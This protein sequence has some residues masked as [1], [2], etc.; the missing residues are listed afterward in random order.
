MKLYLIKGLLLCS[1]MAQAQ[2]LRLNDNSYEHIP[3]KKSNLTVSSKGLPSQVDLSAYVPSVINQGPLGTCVG[4]STTYYMRTMLEA[5]R[6]GIT[7]KKSIDSL[8]F[9]PSY[10]YNII[11]DKSDVSCKMGSEIQDA[12]AYMKTQGVARF[13]EQ[14]YPYCAAN[15]SLKLTEDSKI[16][17]YVKLFDLLDEGNNV[18]KVKATQKALAEGSP[19]VVGV[20]TTPSL[21]DLQ[22]L[23]FWRRLWLQILHFL[24]IDTDAETSLWKPEKSSRLGN[25][26][27]M[28]VVGYDS[29][30][31]GGAFRVVN[32]YGTAWGDDGYFWIRFTDYQDYAKYGFQSYVRAAN[33]TAQVLLSGD[34]SISIADTYK[35]TEPPFTRQLLGRQGRNSDTLV[36][37]SLNDPQQTC[38]PF[39]F[40]S[41]VDKQTYLYVIGGNTAVSSIDTLF[42]GDPSIS[43]IVGANTKIILPSE[44]DNYILFGDAGTEYWLFLFSERPLAMQAYVQ[45]M[46]QRSGSFASR[47]LFAFG[48]ELIPYEQVNYKD[49]KMGFE[50]KGT[51]KGHIV[52]LMISLKHI[53]NPK[54]KQGDCQ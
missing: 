26:H 44:G 12:L 14:G 17:D 47:V 1:I 7:N 31:F 50:L 54:N 34:V 22:E 25:G 48:D 6:L 16:L 15:K 30:R 23:S 3:Q 38:T 20:Q 37:Y 45:K 42:P 10:I 33:D 18:A 43:P 41:N 46:M 52:P 24:G 32:S 53:D 2:G 39:K 49:K 5:M 35:G 40:S 28:C 4:V 19:V 27:A 13:A 9:S 36:A 29:S 21:H 51:H 11:K 8:R